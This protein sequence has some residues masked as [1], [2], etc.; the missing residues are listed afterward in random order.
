MTNENCYQLF[1]SELTSIYFCSSFYCFSGLL[2]WQS[3]S[4]L[5]QSFHFERCHDPLWN[6]DLFDTTMEARGFMRSP[7][8]MST[9]ADGN[10]G[11][12]LEQDISVVLS[13]NSCDWSVVINPFILLV[14]TDVSV[15]MISGSMPY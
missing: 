12:S 14:V 10:C 6:Q 8:Q 15:C 5:F 7:S 13:N 1:E 11:Y 4:Q 2:L 9:P 3:K